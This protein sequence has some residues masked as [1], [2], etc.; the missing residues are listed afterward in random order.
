MKRLIISCLIILFVVSSV[1]AEG[2][3]QQVSQEVTATQ[4]AINKGSGDSASLSGVEIHSQY[5]ERT[6]F[7]FTT[8]P[9][10][11]HVGPSPD[12]VNVW[13]GFPFQLITFLEREYTRKEVME[14]LKRSGIASK[15]LNLKRCGLKQRANFIESPPPTENIEFLAASTLFNPATGSLDSERVQ[16]I[17][18]KY[19]FI[20]TVNG[21]GKKKFVFAEVFWDSM[22][23]AMDNGADMMIF[24]GGMNIIYTGNVVGGGTI[25]GYS[26]E[27]FAL[28]NYLSALFG[29]TKAE[30]ESSVLVICFKRR[31]PE[32]RAKYKDLLSII[33]QPD[34]A[35]A[36][37]DRFL[38][39]GT[40]VI[41]DT[42]T[43]ATKTEVSGPAA[44]EKVVDL[45][46]KAQVLPNGG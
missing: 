26:N 46:K 20:G 11:L 36:I 12:Q 18:K 42:G 10:F 27:N 38:Q 23:K 33:F 43:E 14:V 15:T 6:G 28:G 25:P 31:T 22:R 39:P 3:G 41:E 44:A 17:K 19:Q 24:A 30:A 13:N 34:I 32:E 37:T 16:A 40:T 45:T 7:P 9:N 5:E 29:D 1:W 4:I 35:V 2:E 21:Y 8:F